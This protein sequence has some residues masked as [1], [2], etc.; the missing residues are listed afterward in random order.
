MGAGIVGAHLRKGIPTVMI[1]VSP[2]ALEKGVQSITKVMQSRI[3]IGRATPAD[4]MSVLA[5][6]NTTQSYSQLADREVVIEAV[7]ENE[8]IK[9]KLYRELQ[10]ILAPEAI[11]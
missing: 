6:L 5:L 7:V 4:M 10:A 9:T 3:E 1:D 2:Q 11:L 8:E